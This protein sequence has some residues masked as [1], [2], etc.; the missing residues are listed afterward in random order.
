M[1]A[2]DELLRKTPKP[3]EYTVSENKKCKRG[4]TTLKVVEYSSGRKRHCI[5]KELLE[6]AQ[7][8]EKERGMKR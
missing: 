2:I 1:T 4:Y 5:R 7:Q 8:F 3:W 6:V